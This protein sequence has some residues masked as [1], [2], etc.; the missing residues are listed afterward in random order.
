MKG[1]KHLTQEQM[2]RIELEYSKT[3]NTVM[4]AKVL[5][6]RRS[7]VSQ[8]LKR[9]GI[10]LTGYRESACYKNHDLV[11]QMAKDGKTL[12]DIGRAVG[13]TH[14]R[15]KDYIDRMGIE[16][17]MSDFR[18]DKNSH[19]KGGKTVDKSGYI[20]VKVPNHP[21]ANNH[22][23]VRE[24][25]LVVEKSIGRYLEPDEIVHHIDDNPRNNSLENLRLYSSNAEHLIDT[26]TGQVP[27]W[28]EQG[29]ANILV[30]IRRPRKKKLV[31][32]H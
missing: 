17:K 21:Y 20:L 18:M 15:V 29:K 1:Y 10:E 9:Q 12:S 27:Q 8:Y 3:K 2:K 4:V 23:Y 31:S 7:T 28:T 24:H 30:G 16:Y 19:W 13:T 32:S 26:I 6:I 14:H 11:V 25:R 22:G 5:G